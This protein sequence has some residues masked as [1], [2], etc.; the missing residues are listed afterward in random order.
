MKCFLD[1]KA[2]LCSGGGSSV[3]YSKGKHGPPLMPKLFITSSR[4]ALIFSG[5]KEVQESEGH[6]ENAQRAEGNSEQEECLKQSGFE[7]INQTFRCDP[8][9]GQNSEEDLGMVD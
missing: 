6:Y 8:N 7:S 1:Q 3:P 5:H 9:R 2:R 4:L